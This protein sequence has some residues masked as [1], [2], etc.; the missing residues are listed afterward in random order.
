VPAVDLRFR[1]NTV[2]ELRFV[3]PIGSDC[4][5]LFLVGSRVFYGADMAVTPHSGAHHDYIKTVRD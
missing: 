1:S 3:V 4:S 2:F 5:R